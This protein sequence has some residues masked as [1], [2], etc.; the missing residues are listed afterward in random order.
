MTD[1]LLSYVMCHLQANEPGEPSD[2]ST[3]LPPRS[4]SPLLSC[5]FRASTADSPKDG[6]PYDKLTAL[7]FGLQG[8]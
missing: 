3:I 4:S 7:W 5:P 6:A 2:S 1:H 8:A